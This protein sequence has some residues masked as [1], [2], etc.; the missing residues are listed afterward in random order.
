MN[1]FYAFGL[2]MALAIPAI[3]EEDKKLTAEFEAGI[4]T[5]SG[6]TDTESYKGKLDIKHDMTSWKNHYVL[7]GLFNRGDVEL[8]DGTTEKQTTNE[9]YFGSAQSDYKISREH[10]SFFVYGEYDRNR[11]SGFDYQYTIAVGYADRLFTND[12]SYLAYNIGPG[13]TVSQE[14]EDEETQ[15]RPDKEESFIIRI[16]LEYMYQISDNAKF[17]Q[18][19]SSNYSTDSDKNTKTKSVTAITAQLNSSLSLRASY[20]ID[21]NSEVADDRKHADTQTAVTVVY[22]F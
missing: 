1:K 15:I 9:K 20:T 7:E 13:M 16:A 17:T 21:Y 10:A 14:E 2:A 22:S 3:A 11:F 12:N 5:T 18:N 4:I 6:N 19:I 8:D